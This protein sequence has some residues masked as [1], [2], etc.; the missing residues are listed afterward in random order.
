MRQNSRSCDKTNRKKQWYKIKIINKK[1]INKYWRQLTFL[2]FIVFASWL[3]INII[4]LI[5]A[6][7]KPV[8]VL[9]VLGGSIQREIYV[10]KEATENP[11][12]RIL[13]SG[14]SQDPCIKLIFQRYSA[15]LQ[16]GNLQSNILQSNILQSNILQSTILQ[17]VWLE[18]CAQSTFANFYYA[19]PI[20]RQWRVHKVKLIT[21]GSH[22]PRAKWMAQILFGAHGIW[23][24]P[25]IIQEKG[26]PGNRESWLKTSLDLTRSLLWAII[27]QFI[28]PQCG[29]VIK[30]AD[31]D[32]DE[33]LDRGFTCER[34]GQIKN[35]RS[36]SPQPTS[37]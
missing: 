6:S 11:Q 3:I 25:D 1:I 30:L 7:S 17:N 4:A 18:K 31:V 22:L 36:K 21:S 15:N 5:S 12:T 35:P 8:D 32:M 26:V 13:I 23:V 19:I 20:L 10:A 34:Q 24:E 14:G 16:S 27:S 29:E 9:V 37:K 28:Q 2:F 33:W